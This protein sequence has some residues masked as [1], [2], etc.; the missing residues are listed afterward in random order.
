MHHFRRKHPG[1]FTLIELLVVIAIIAILIGLLLPAVQKVRDAAA[2]MTCSNNLHQIGIGL[3]NYHDA[4]GTLPAYGFD[5]GTPGNPPM[6]TNPYISN[7]G[8]SLFGLI[9]P[10]LEQQNVVNLARADHPVVDPLNLPPPLGDCLAGLQQIK[11]YQ[12]PSAPERFAD[13]GPYFR[14]VPVPAIQA[15]FT[16]P[17]ANAAIPLGITDYAVAQQ[18]SGAFNSNCGYRPAPSDTHGLLGNKGMPRKLTDASDGTTNTILIV[19]DAGRPTLYVK[20]QSLGLQALN[21]AWADYNTKV[22]VDGTDP[23]GMSQGRGCCVINCTNNDEIYSFHTA[24]A[25][26]LRADGSVAFLSE[27]ISAATL[28]AL[29]TAN[30]GE[31]IPSY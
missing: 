20:R 30:G 25:N 23:T 5:F 21:S 8:H 18:T 11:V 17:N 13:Y 16:G 29:V 31:V 14:T 7:Q 12:C 3:H 24:G 2:R 26:V 9:L 22:T 19:E 4:N 27:N 1:G 10:Y 15:K 6:P 28:G